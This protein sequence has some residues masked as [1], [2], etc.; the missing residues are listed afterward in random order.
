MLLNV[1]LGFQR[2]LCA[3]RTPVKRLAFECVLICQIQ[4]MKHLLLF[5]LLSL[6]SLHGSTQTICDSIDVKHV[7]YDLFEST[8]FV[9]VVAKSESTMQLSYPRFQLVD[10]NG[11]LIAKQAE[12]NFFLMSDYYAGFKLSLETTS[13]NSIFPDS[14]LLFYSSDSLLCEFTDD[15]DLC[16][17]QC[18]PMGIST[19]TLGQPANRRS[20][21][22]EVKDENAQTVATGSLVVDTASYYD[23]DSVCLTAG[24]Y[25]VAYTETETTGPQNIRF[26]A[27][28]PYGIFGPSEIS[29]Q[30]DVSLE[31]T[32]LEKCIEE[33]S[34][35]GLTHAPS[36]SLPYALLQSKDRLEIQSVSGT[37]IKGVQLIDVQGRTV[38]NQPMN[39]TN[40]RL[41]TES[42]PPSIYILRM[43]LGADVFSSKVVIRH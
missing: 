13:S 36:A 43:T 9:E 27:S 34:V 32:V 11:V 4:P 6:F 40:V 3:T 20:F 1:P 12:P 18:S 15:Y 19:F 16:T 41:N 25:T 31:F 23:S 10:A 24:D 26:A 35:T 7:R 29:D 37:S 28:R 21:D 39:Q 42:V 22:F 17:S 8:S 30:G 33:D 38:Y 14:K 5:S 2:H